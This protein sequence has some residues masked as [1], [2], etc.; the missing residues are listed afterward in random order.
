MA[1][2]GMAGFFVRRAGFESGVCRALSMRGSS[3]RFSLASLPR[4]TLWKIVLAGRASWASNLVDNRDPRAAP[5]SLFSGR[6]MSWRWPGRGRNR[7]VAWRR[8]I[9]TSLT[10]SPPRVA[11][12]FGSGS[13]LTGTK[14]AKDDARA[15]RQ[16]SVPPAGA[17]SR[18]HK[19]RPRNSRSVRAG[20]FCLWVVR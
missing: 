18:P 13:K 19:V 3:S 17:V 10:S 8:G 7:L 5:T 1:S 6:D 14:C 9:T 4:R 12:V 15:L 2:S 11:P 20:N 16:P